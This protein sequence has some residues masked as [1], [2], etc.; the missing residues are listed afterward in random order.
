MPPTAWNNFVNKNYLKG[1]IDDKDYT[2]KQ[3]MR[4]SSEHKSDMSGGKQD[5]ENGPPRRGENKTVY[6]IKKNGKNT[7]KSRY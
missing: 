1:K 4:Y 7:R 3:A 5:E 2:L 6:F